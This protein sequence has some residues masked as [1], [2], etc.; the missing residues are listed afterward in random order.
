[1]LV[2]ILPAPLHGQLRAIPSKSQAHRLLI[3]AALADR[4]TELGCAAVSQDIA[5]TAD[6]LRALGAETDY[7]CGGFRVTPVR[8][9]VRGAVL[10]CG[11]SGSTLRFLLPLVCALGAEGSF[12]LHG[13]L[14]D[15]PLSPLWEVLE[16][17]GAVLGRPDQRTVTF[18]GRLRGGE[19]AIA[20]DVSSQFLSG[21][22]FALPLLE[23]RSSLV[24]L[25][26]LESRG[27][28]EMT[29]QAEAMFGVR[30][31]GRD[32]GE[33]WTPEPGSRY[34]SPGYAE[35]EGDWS[36]AAFWLAADA[37]SGGSVKLTGLDPASAQGDRAAEELIPRI[38]AGNA[39]IDAGDIPD[40]VPPLAV[41]AAAAPGKTEF[42]NAGRLRLKESDRIRSVRAMLEALGGRV[43][44]TPDSLTVFGGG[45]R[46]GTVDSF[47]DHRIAMAAAVA[48][49]A[50]RE[51][52]CILGAEA[53]NKSYPAFWSDYRLLGGSVRE[54]EA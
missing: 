5:A 51:P 29:R 7:R 21:L 11:E 8:Q 35:V 34:R 36:N 45:L 3:C 43:A 10:D 15:R 12:R 37:L 19:Y 41:T 2:T 23:E 16:A 17:H 9:P 49:I 28:L 46:G 52:V 39:V 38:L 13:R 33:A 25:G 18:S 32:A 40:L 53:V 42:V 22:L 54:E 44:E 50:C 4:P 14:P 26:R 6:C 48:A 27:Y 1:M 20:G 31:Q 24:P 47:R 30:W